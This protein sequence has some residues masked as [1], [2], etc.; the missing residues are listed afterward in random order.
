MRLPVGHIRL[1]EEMTQ[2]EGRYKQEIC[3]DLIVLYAATNHP[4][5]LRDT[6]TEPKPVEA[7]VA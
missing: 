4:D 2:R 1:L 6:T 5:L 3:A 7:A